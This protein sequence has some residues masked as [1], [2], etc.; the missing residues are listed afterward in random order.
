M[1]TW[2]HATE[3][4]RAVALYNWNAEISAA[5]LEILYHLEVLFRNAVD[6]QFPTSETDDQ[7]TILKPDVWLCDPS[8]MTDESREKVNDAIGR[9]QRERKRPTRGRDRLI[10]LR[11]LASPFQRRI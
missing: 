2:R 7:L 4:D 11:L 9:L 10:V 3:H 8:V 1:P 5:F 6:R